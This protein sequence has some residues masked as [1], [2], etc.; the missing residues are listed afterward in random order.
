MGPT[1]LNTVKFISDEDSSTAQSIYKI[2]IRICKCVIDEH[3]TNKYSV[4]LHL[5]VYLCGTKN[6]RCFLVEF[7]LDLSNLYD[8]IDWVIE[9]E[10]VREKIVY[11]S[12]MI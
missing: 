5:H 8:G 10:Y 11:N 3:R 4:H 7:Q 6:C 12:L 1:K 9:I 2:S